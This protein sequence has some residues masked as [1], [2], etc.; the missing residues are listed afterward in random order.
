MLITNVLNYAK[1][2]D[3]PGMVIGSLL[4]FAMFTVLGHA[5]DALAAVSLLALIAVM[6]Y[7]LMIK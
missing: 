3:M 2:L 7:Q 1:N 4:G 6:G 5:S